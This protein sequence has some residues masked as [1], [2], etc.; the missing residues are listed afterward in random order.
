MRRQALG[1]DTRPAT[2]LEADLAKAAALAKASQ[3][4]APADDW[5]HMDLGASVDMAINAE[6]TSGAEPEAKEA[7]NDR[8]VMLPKDEIDSL[9]GELQWSE[10]Q[11]RPLILSN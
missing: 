8:T 7:E 5:E 9:L 11:Q 3:A 10:I 2:E 6:K 1:G 4:P